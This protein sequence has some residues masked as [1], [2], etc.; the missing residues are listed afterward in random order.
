MFARGGEK[1]RV[2]FR[3]EREQVCVIPEDGDVGLPRKKTDPGSKNL[4]IGKQSSGPDT[5][6][7]GE[8][9]EHLLLNLVEV[10]G[11]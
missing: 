8:N 9:T 5:N 6:W 1:S 2:C 4:G 7:G 3:K 10:I 11:N